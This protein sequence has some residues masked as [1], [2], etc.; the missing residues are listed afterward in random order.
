MQTTT[1]PEASGQTGKSWTYWPAIDGLRAIAVLSVVLFHLDHRIVPG[2]FV[3]VDMF[4]VISGFL[5]SSILIGDIEAREFSIG[6]FYQRRISRIFPALILV[7]LT[8]IAVASFVYAAQDM[9]SLGINA[10][11]AA[12]SVLNMKLMVQG[13]Y[14]AMSSDAQPLLHYWSLAVEEQFYLVFPLYLWFLLRH[15]RRPLA[16]TA[17]LGAA[18]F[19]LCVAL[20]MV[21][22]PL[23]FYLLPT[24]AWELLA[25]SFLA[26]CRAGGG[27]ITGRRAD[28][29][30]WGGLVL[31]AGSIALLHESDAFPGWVAAFPVIGTALLI[32]P[33]GA[34]APLPLRLLSHPA[35]VAI[36]KRSYSLYL[37]HWPVFSLVDYHFYLAGDVFRT[38][39]KLTLTVVLTLLSYAL[40]ERPAR[41]FLNVRRRRVPLF[42]ATALLVTAI[43]A[44]GVWMRSAFYVD[45][46][47]ATIPGGGT[48]V[49]GGSKGVVILSGDSQ[50]GM[51]GIEIS[52][53]ARQRGFTLHA[54]GTPGHNQLPDQSGTSW[55]AVATLIDE[56]KPYLVIL[57]N[58]WSDKLSRNPKALARAVERLRGHARHVL[59]VSEPPNLPA[60]VSRDSIR[61]GLRPPFRETLADRA[62]RLTGLAR[63]RA[64][65]G[66]AVQVIDVAPLFLDSGGGIRLIAED[67]RL[68][69]FDHYHLSDSGTRIVRPVLD[70]AISDALNR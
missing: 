25:G 13:S 65:E 12:A 31:L 62:R 10:T 28:V 44:G 24:R 63:L 53:I 55:P 60:N 18:S 15:T 6:R 52:R 64:L 20:T 23:A 34:A 19:A 42:V 47:A 37:W 61:R 27:R 16:I 45:A 2:G 32:A 49:H 17:L 69:Y 56:K 14:F 54:L 11:A 39:L 9:A 7:L 51:Y 5:I 58:A 30:V 70:K 50:A 68:T 59:L 57:I 46:S 33:V 43:G 3:G 29:A 40:V 4:F 36:G 67:G 48:T 66:P 38:T 41:G 21:H 26:L 8:T 22:Q 1:V 35:M